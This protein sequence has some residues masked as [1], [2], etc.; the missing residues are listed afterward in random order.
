[1]AAQ[2]ACGQINNKRIEFPIQGTDLESFNIP[3]QTFGG[4]WLQYKV[5]LSSATKNLSPELYAV[6]ITYT[7]FSLLPS[8]KYKSVDITGLISVSF[9]EYDAPLPSVRNV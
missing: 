5:E 4:K 7:A 2:I 8:L 6:T 3:L 1:M 9:L